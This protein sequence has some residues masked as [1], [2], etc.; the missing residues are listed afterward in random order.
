MGWGLGGT[1]ASGGAPARLDRPIS[2]LIGK[3]KPALNR[4]RLLLG[5]LSSCSCYIIPLMSGTLFWADSFSGISATI[6]SV[7]RMFLAIEAAF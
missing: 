3:Q 7:V 5:N 2:L 6:A 1:G 4:G